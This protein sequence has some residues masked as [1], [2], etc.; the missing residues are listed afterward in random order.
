M[1]SL[2]TE[3]EHTERPLKGYGMCNTCYHRWARHKKK[4]GDWPPPPKEKTLPTCGHPERQYW[5]NGLCKSCYNT[6]HVGDSPVR[7]AKRNQYEK[8]WQEQNPEQ[9]ARI[10]RLSHLRKTYGLS[11]ADYE[12]LLVR[13]N[14]CCEICLAPF[15]D[16]VPHVDHCHASNEVRGVLCANCNHGLGNFRDTPRFL[17]GALAYLSRAHPDRL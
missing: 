11:E 3:C 4:A 9:W 2:A 16:K 6:K 12:A 8:E 5:A 10:R 17:E 7:R 13:S 14:N 1:R 15:K